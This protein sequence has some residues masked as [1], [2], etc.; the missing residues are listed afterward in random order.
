MAAIGLT[1][2]LI[3][4]RPSWYAHVID[5]KLLLCHTLLTCLIPKLQKFRGIKDS[6]NEQKQADQSSSGRDKESRSHSVPDTHV[7]P[8]TRTSSSFPPTELQALEPTSS[9]R[10]TSGLTRISLSTTTV[11]AASSSE[12]LG[13][14]LV[15]S[16]QRPVADLILVHG[17]GGS[18]IRTWCWNRD[19]DLFWPSWLASEPILQNLRVFSFGYN[20]SFKG[21]DTGLG[22]LEFAKDL[23]LQMSVWFSESEDKI[24]KVS[25]TYC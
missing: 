14:H 5:I 11:E 20:A 1:S 12:S 10:S 23:L 25:L 4:F 7:R 21:S 8:E 17:L 18:R 22:I 3:F 6:R 2:T 15:H 16:A 13:L 19:R 24:G 9:R